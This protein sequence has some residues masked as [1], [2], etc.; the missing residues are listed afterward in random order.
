MSGSGQDFSTKLTEAA[1]TIGKVFADASLTLGGSA[2]AVAG[3]VDAA[4]A[5]VLQNLE[6]QSKGFGETLTSLQ[7]QLAAKLQESAQRSLSAGEA[8]ATASTSIAR[9]AM[10]A[11][12]KGIDEVI[13]T[14][15]EDI[16]AALPTPLRSV[17]A[18][19]SGQTV[20]IE[21][22]SRALRDTAEAF[23]KV[24]S[25]V[26]S[27]S[28][29]LLTHSARVADS[30]ERMATSIA[31]SVETLSAT[32]QTADGIAARL[33]EHLAQIAHV[34]DQYELRFKS[35]DEDLGKAADRFHEEVSRHQEAMREFVKGVDDHT[36]NI[37]GKINSAVGSLSESVESLNETLEGF[38]QAMASR[39]AAEVRAKRDGLSRSCF[40]HR[41]RR[42]ELLH[43]DDRYDG[44][45]AFHLHYSAHEFRPSVSTPNRRP[46]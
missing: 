38:L 6:V 7:T 16:A 10:D 27:A 40:Q 12:R 43:F 37:L 29:P 34:W 26:R 30:T 17:S 24:A 39:E 14:L 41:C 5:Q 33:S 44:R 8:A 32:Q 13:L 31:G 1:E 9:D 35:V 42:R 25:D 20:Q 36:G 46:S 4:M 23:G 28:Q 11:V 18:A 3:T 22:I 45:D 21:T 15:R 19:L 2:A